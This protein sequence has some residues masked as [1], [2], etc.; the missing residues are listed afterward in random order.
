MYLET[1]AANLRTRDK[2][3]VEFIIGL[4][5]IPDPVRKSSSKVFSLA[6]SARKVCVGG[7][8]YNCGSNPHGA[9]LGAERL[10]SVCDRRSACFRKIIG[11]YLLIETMILTIERSFGL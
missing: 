1:L 7:Y 5:L 9:G 6:E 11:S 4:R 8:I 10:I 3:D 2:Y